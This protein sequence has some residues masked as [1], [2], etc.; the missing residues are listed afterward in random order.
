M[1]SKPQQY[2]EMSG[3]ELNATAALHTKNA[4]GS[5][6]IEFWVDL[7]VGFNVVRKRKYLPCRKS[8]ADQYASSQSRGYL[9]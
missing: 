5:H 3:G 6:W 8:K 1:N 7:R 2:T 9:T 4:P